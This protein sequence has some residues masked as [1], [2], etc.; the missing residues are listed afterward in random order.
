MKFRPLAPLTL[1]AVIATT[2]VA[3]P[4]GASEAV[5]CD[6]RIATIVGT[7]ASETIRGTAG[8]DVIVGLAGQDIIFGLG[9][10]DIICG[11]AGGD[12]IHGGFGD[13]R[14]L[15]GIGPDSLHGGGGDDWLSGAQGDDLV[16]GND[17]NDLAYGAQHSDFVDGGTGND[18]VFGGAG[19]DTVFGRGGD[20]VV[21][22]G[23][24]EDAIFGNNGEDIVNGSGGPD[25]IYGGNGSDLLRVDDDDTVIEGGTGSD[26]INGVDEADFEPPSTPD[27]TITTPSGTTTT[28]DEPTTTTTTNETLHEDEFETLVE[29]ELYRLHQC[30][31]TGD[32]NTWCEDGDEA[33]WNITAAE[34]SL[35]NGQ[36]LP[37]LGRSDQADASAKSWSQQLTDTSTFTHSPNAGPLY[38]ENI[39]QLSTLDGYTAAEADAVAAEIM[40][41]WINSAGHRANILGDHAADSAFG[42]GVEALDV[43]AFRTHNATVQIHRG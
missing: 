6:G 9:G 41:L 24:G 26:L 20:D 2:A 25:E 33:G 19:H 39:A 1:A 43:G 34:R 31:R 4:V 21:N 16:Y 22:G 40:T 8:D 7:S 17:G 18:R 14:I 36:P 28:P 15:G 38:A 3:S 35:S 10:N 5:R 11:N 32:Y 30:A 12:T 23:S 29:D 37:F 27:A 13:D 42:F